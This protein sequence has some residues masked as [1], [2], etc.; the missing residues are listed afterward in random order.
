ML[1]LISFGKETL[2][3]NLSQVEMP[4]LLGLKMMEIASGFII[5]DGTL[6]VCSLNKVNIAT[7]VCVIRLNWNWG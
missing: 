7:S 2:F 4:I 1:P 3:G 6:V 5:S